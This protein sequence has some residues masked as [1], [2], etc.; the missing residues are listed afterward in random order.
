MTLSI[1]GNNKAMREVDLSD[2]S[3]YCLPLSDLPVDTFLVKT[4]DL[5]E[6][7]FHQDFSIELKVLS[8]HHVGVG[9]RH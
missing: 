9:H 7:T 6:W 4:V 3:R 8:G 5:H 1:A 2:V